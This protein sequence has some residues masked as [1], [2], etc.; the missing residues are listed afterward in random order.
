MLLLLLRLLRLLL[1]RVLRRLL[2][3]L[4]VCWLYGLLLVTQLI[5]LLSLAQFALVCKS[6][7]VVFALH[8]RGR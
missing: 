4:G 5:V 3:E 7:L 2:I 8:I 1:H 6:Q